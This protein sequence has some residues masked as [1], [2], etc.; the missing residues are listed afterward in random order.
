MIDFHC[1]LDLYPKPTEIAS[2]CEREGLYVLSVTTTPSAWPGTRSLERGH[3]R[4]ALGLHPQLAH[5]RLGELSQFDEFLPRARYVGEVG[6]D[7]APEFRHSWNEQLRV[8]DHILSS[9]SDV[10]GRVLSIHSRRAARHV[11]DRLSTRPDAGIPILHWFTG[12]IAE[13]EHAIDMGCWFSVGP[14]ML[15]TKSGRKLVSRMPRDRILTESDGPFAQHSQQPLFPWDVTLAVKGI[16]SLWNTDAASAQACLTT[17]LRIL[18]SQP[19]AVS[20]A[21]QS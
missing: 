5:Q 14:P 7:G 4:T 8:F 17:N 2:R 1:H 6:L 13:L 11:L 3:I 10:G 12:T 21:A 9:C 18:A 15:S 16:A 19:P 20:S